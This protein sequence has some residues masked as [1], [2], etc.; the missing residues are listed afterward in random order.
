ML[1]LLGLELL[2]IGFP[3]LRLLVLTPGTHETRA[4]LRCGKAGL[5]YS[6]ASTE[7]FTVKADP[8]TEKTRLLQTRV[9]LVLPSFLG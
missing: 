2:P 7:P 8:P 4:S 1:Q 9:L 5:H 6:T 3:A